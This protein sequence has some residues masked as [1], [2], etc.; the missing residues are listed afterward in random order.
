LIKNILEDG[1]LIRG[2]YEYDSEFIDD[3]TCLEN[4]D[5]RMTDDIRKTRDSKLKYQSLL[6]DLRGNKVP[7]DLMLELSDKLKF[8]KRSEG[9]D[10]YMGRYAITQPV[11]I[12]AFYVFFGSKLGSDFIKRWNDGEDKESLK[13][14][15]ENHIYEN[16]YVNLGL[17]EMEL[18]DFGTDEHIKSSENFIRERKENPGRTVEQD[19]GLHE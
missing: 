11:L 7:S 19:F 5:Y 13:E 1:A 12:D 6:Q 18:K 8:N 3:D 16:P 4:F 15:F 2:Q 10:I 14:E 9:D 17:V